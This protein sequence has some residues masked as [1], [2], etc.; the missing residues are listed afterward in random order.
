MIQAGK[1]PAGF[2]DHIE[3]RQQFAV[4]RIFSEQIAQDFSE[5]LMLFK[6]LLWAL[7]IKRQVTPIN[8]D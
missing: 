3:G 2:A 6:V 5:I 8:R 1:V 4:F 7:N